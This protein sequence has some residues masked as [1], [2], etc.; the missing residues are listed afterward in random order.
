MVISIASST[1][2]DHDSQQS[3]EHVSMDTITG[4]QIESVA[5]KTESSHPQTTGYYGDYI[6]YVKQAEE[7]SHEI[8]AMPVV[9]VQPIRIEAFGS[10]HLD[11]LHDKD[12]KVA[13]VMHRMRSIFQT[14][15][16]TK[17]FTSVKKQKMFGIKRN[18]IKNA[19]Y[20][21]KLL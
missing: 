11:V 13:I 12:N 2:E 20:F 1:L 16:V 21:L 8:P 6:D 19:Q 18:T 17:W 14:A 7:S 3:T 9:H 15:K 10:N 5:I 4:D